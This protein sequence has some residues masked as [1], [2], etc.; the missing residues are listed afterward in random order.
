[1]EGGERKL[2]EH[3]G[4]EWS[5]MGDGFTWEST[6]LDETVAK[7]RHAWEV[8]RAKLASGD[9]D[10]LILDELTYAVTYGWIDVADVVDGIMGRAPRPTSSSPGVTR[11][12]SSS[13][14]PT[15]SRR[16]AR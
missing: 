14:S 11:R 4:I 1:M 13:R 6:D 10:L 7:G 15:R 9:Y 16:C 8:S 3:L 12:P 2:A 5:T